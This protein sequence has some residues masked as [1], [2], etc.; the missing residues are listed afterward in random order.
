LSKVPHASSCSDGEL[1]DSNNK[2]DDPEE[3]KQVTPEDITNMIRV[4]NTAK[5]RVSLVKWS[6]DS[7]EVGT[8][9]GPH[10]HNWN[11]KDIGKDW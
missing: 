4:L 1:L 6:T 9:H 10:Y 5:E 3:P 7:H 2:S 11:G 8:G